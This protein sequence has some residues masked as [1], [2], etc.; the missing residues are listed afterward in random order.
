MDLGSA[1]L[2]FNM[3]SIFQY[4]LPRFLPKSPEESWIFQCVSKRPFNLKY[5]P[6]RSFVGESEEPNIR[7]Y[8]I[9]FFQSNFEQVFP[10]EH[11][12]PR[13]S[14]FFFSIETPIVSLGNRWNILGIIYIDGT[15]LILT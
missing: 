12:R 4:G 1:I 13:I 15:I 10:L 9:L 6:L 3:D 14:D 8:F 11:A 7:E 2:K 5:V